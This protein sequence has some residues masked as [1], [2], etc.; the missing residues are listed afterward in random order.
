MRKALR[1]GKGKDPNKYQA[2]GAILEKEFASWTEIA[3]AGKILQ[4]F[5]ETR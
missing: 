1:S 2:C 3:Q 4:E 5:I